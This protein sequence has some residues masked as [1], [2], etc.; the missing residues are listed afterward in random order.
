MVQSKN[1]PLWRSAQPFD[2][3]AFR[4]ELKEEQRRQREAATANGQI[5][6]VADALAHVY[7]IK[8][9][10]DRDAIRKTV[11]PHPLVPVSREDAA[12][13]ESGHFLTDEHEGFHAATA[14][15]KG[16]PFGWG[17]KTKNCSDLDFDLAPESAPH[18]P[19][20]FSRNARA[21]LAG[22]IA[23][24]L[25]GGGSVFEN[26]AELIQARVYSDRAAEL[27]PDLYGVLWIENVRR[28]VAIVEHYQ[29]QILKLAEMLARRREITR[30]QPSVR[31][32]LTTI[33]S[34]A[35]LPMTLSPEGKALAHRI[36]AET[37]CV[38]GFVVP[39]ERAQ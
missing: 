8:T 10:V 32:V 11:S 14:C 3:A 30:L 38:A 24:E 20:D 5:D 2:D 6:L 12:I 27:T 9:P 39:R 34:R 31:K 19:K 35:P 28:T 13:H 25:I 18:D 29:L 17:G 23:E 33:M 22:P 1:S 15:I 21:I 7:G 36:I 4:R 26:F 16:S 37:P